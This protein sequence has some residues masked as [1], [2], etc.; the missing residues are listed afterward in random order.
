[1]PVHWIDV[2]VG[3]IGYNGWP[4]AAA[5]NQGAPEGGRP[6]LWEGRYI[7]PDFAQATGYLTTV[8]RD[9]QTSTILRLDL[10]QAVR[11]LVVTG[12]DSSDSDGLAAAVRD[13]VPFVIGPDE[14]IL[15][16]LGRHN[17]AY[18]GPSPADAG[19]APNFELGMSEQLFARLGGTEHRI[20]V[21]TMRNHSD[22]V[23]WTEYETPTPHGWI[24]ND[25]PLTRQECP[26]DFPDA[27]WL[28]TVRNLGE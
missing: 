27:E 24:P 3:F 21:A 10:G 16:A 11:A 9:Q 18:I 19:E 5:P 20:G 7:A 26:T 25:P 14:Q 23:L 28:G 4:D 15:S 8:T 2:A 12:I 22:V 17:L 13:A 1:M 6:F